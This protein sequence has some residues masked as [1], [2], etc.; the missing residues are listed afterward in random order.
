MNPVQHTSYGINLQNEVFQPA[1]KSLFTLSLPSSSP[2]VEQKNSSSDQNLI[3]REN[4]RLDWIRS[5]RHDSEG[6]AGAAYN[7]ASSVGS[8]MLGAFTCP[9]SLFK[10]IQNAKP[11]LN[12]SVNCIARELGR[13]TERMNAL[14]HLDSARFQR[15]ARAAETQESSLNAAITACEEGLR[16]VNAVQYPALY[17]A[18]QEERTN[19]RD[20]ASKIEL[21]GIVRSHTV[22]FSRTWQESV[23]G[24]IGAAAAFGSGI[25][26]LA[27]RNLFVSGILGGLSSGG[28]QVALQLLAHEGRGAFH[29]REDWN[30][31]AQAMVVGAICGVVGTSVGRLFSPSA[32]RTG[33]QIALTQAADVLTEVLADDAVSKLFSGQRNISNRL[34]LHTEAQAPQNEQRFG[35]KLFNNWAGEILGDRWND[36]IHHRFIA[37]GRL[38]IAGRIQEQRQREALNQSLALY[39]NSE[40]P[41][42][43][44]QVF[45]PYLAAVNTNNYFDPNT[46]AANDNDIPWGQTNRQVSVPEQQYLLQANGV[47]ILISNGNHTHNNFRMSS[48]AAASMW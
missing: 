40:T 21:A 32:S 8:L 3:S 4:R 43:P 35:W 46:E 48:D 26:A 36:G 41:S 45:N 44:S 22:V 1:E 30:K 15:L 10:N 9:D 29:T 7:I 5:V 38:D 25:L 37:H 19:L 39:I 16:N 13:Y 24:L 34:G 28:L 31:L 11:E 33:L 23:T 14:L 17:E 27:S 18:Y 6:I 42:T 2:T 12:Q 20:A 47:P